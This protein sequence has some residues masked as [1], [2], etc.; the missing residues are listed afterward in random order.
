MNLL[1]TLY[2][3]FKPKMASP[4]VKAKE[5]QEPMFAVTNSDGSIKQVPVSEFIKRQGGVVQKTPKP[6]KISTK[7]PTKAPTKSP[8]RSPQVLGASSDFMFNSLPFGKTQIPQPPQEVG[9]A[10]RKY[11]PN[12]AT[13]SAIAAWS[14]SGYSPQAQGKNRDGSLDRGLM[15][16]NSNTFADY[17]RR[18][19][20]IMEQYGIKSY[21]DMYDM[22]KNI[23][24]A[25][26]IR[27][28]Q[29]WDAWYGPGNQGFDL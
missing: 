13:Q 18:M 1:E 21:E 26:L 28:Y 24:M 11:F 10:L 20:G 25:N 3:L 2:G 16:I 7:A 8:T 22:I 27:K 15:Q 9:N 14:E 12:E 19:P 6:T 17:K 23:Q 4:L 5:P 29:G